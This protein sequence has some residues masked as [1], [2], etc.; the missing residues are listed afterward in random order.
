M[1]LHS[2]FR[3][4]VSLGAAASLAL[5][6]LQLRAG[7]LD[8]EVNDMF[9]SLGAVGNYSAPGAF[10]GQTYNTLTG[11]SLYVRSPNRTYQLLAMN[12]PSAKAGCGGID[13][14]GGSM[15]AISAEEFKAMLQNITSALP[16][17]AFQVALDAVSP[18]LG[19]ITKWAK[20]LESWINNARINSCETASSLVSNAMEA[21]GVSATDMCAKIAVSTGLEPDINKARQRCKNDRASIL[22]TSRDSGGPD[23]D[24]V[25]FVGN[26]TW[27][28]LQKVPDLDDASREIAMSI[29]G[30]YIYYPEETEKQPDVFAPTIKDIG[31][32]L[33]GQQDA[34][35]GKV[36]MQML[37]CN[38]YSSC[39]T[40]RYEDVEHTPLTTRVEQLMT[41]IADH[42]RNRAAYGPA[43]GRLINF[44]NATSIPIWRLLAIGSTTPNSD[45]N[46]VLI[47]NYKH[48]VATDY[49]MMFLNRFASVG[50]SALQRNYRLDKNQKEDANRLRDDLQ[51]FLSLLHADL[52]AKYQKLASVSQVTADI[53]QL[54]RRLRVNMS[55]HVSDMLRQS[56]LGPR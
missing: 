26:L 42:I 36:R 19:G 10:K 38:N 43:D 14:F 11:G 54:D 7:N 56:Y 28:A 30:T 4:I 47:Q 45:L 3:K 1:K 20:S 41:Q 37:K 27:V 17:I 44:V 13:L 25:P 32:L 9:N 23:S 18:L 46:T 49:A 6:P 40:V 33:N 35:S 34:G 53:E 2:Y 22:K 48:V 50:L 52:S 15:S 16:G 5:A 8:A 29:I 21:S 55:S 51:H 39:D 31:T 12:Y 24:L